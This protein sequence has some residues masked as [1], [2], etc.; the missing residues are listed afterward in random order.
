MWNPMMRF[1]RWQRPWG[2]PQELMNRTMWWSRNCY[3]LAPVVALGSGALVWAVVWQWSSRQQGARAGRTLLAPLAKLNTTAPAA[4]PLQT[5]HQAG[6]PVADELEENEARTPAVVAEVLRRAPLYATSE[7]R[8][9]V[10]GF[11]RDASQWSA[12][13]EALWLVGADE[14]L[15]W[16]RGATQSGDEVETGLVELVQSR[17]IPAALRD[18]ALQ[19]LGIWAEEHAAGQDVLRAL[20]TL[21]TAESASP[22]AGH[23]LQALCRSCF[24]PDAVLW[25]RNAALQLA[26]NPNAHPQSKI[27]AIEAAGHCGFEEVEQPARELLTHAQTVNE[28]VTA[29]QVLGWVGSRGTLEWLKPQPVFTEILTAAAQKQAL[30]TLHQ[31]WGV[32]ETK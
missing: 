6:A 5:G 21:V 12:E 32:G 28:R 25:I 10:W 26:T 1:G 27:A 8:T 2:G 22:L 18:F 23:A 24:A 9:L 30:R 14:A 19:H 16:L 11:L 13:G 20:Q 29:L 7:E 17:R 15:S 4:R 31:R 3:W